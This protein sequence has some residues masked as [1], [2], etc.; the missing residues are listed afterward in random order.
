MA[1]QQRVILYGDTLILAGV[2]ASL[3][4]SP[5]LD[6]FPLN[7]S[8]VDLAETLNWLHPSA[9][10]FDLGSVQPDFPLALLQ[11]SNLLLIGIDPDSSKLLV[12]SSQ[13]APALA[14]ADLLSVIEQKGLKFE[15][16]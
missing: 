3:N 9:V 2:L 10:I 13:Q 1:E 7:G 8:P 11:Q 12:L 16:R 5:N 4:A 15:E 14:V 6:I